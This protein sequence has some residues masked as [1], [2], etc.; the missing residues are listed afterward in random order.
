VL[1]ELHVTN[2]LGSDWAG[3]VSKRRAPEAGI[4]LLGNRGATGLRT[5]LEYQRLKSGSSQ[6]KG[7][8]QAIVSAADYYYVASLGHP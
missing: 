3:Y 7:S 4:K 6:I 2:D 5:T 8:D 1:V